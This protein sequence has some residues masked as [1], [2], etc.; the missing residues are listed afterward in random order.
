[1]KVKNTEYIV[2]T[3][4]DFETSFTMLADMHVDTGFDTKKY[5]QI[6]EQIKRNESEYIAIL[7]DLVENINIE[8]LDDVLSFVERITKYASKTFVVLGNHDQQDKSKEACENISLV[9]GLNKI[10]NLILLNNQ[11]FYGLKNAQIAGFN[12]GCAKDETK[13]KFLSQINSGLTA[14]FDEDTFNIIMS[15]SPFN[16]EGNINNITVGKNCDL[17]LAGHTHS[18][19][20]PPIAKP[21]IP[22]NRGITKP[23][24]H[25]EFSKNIRGTFETDGVR[26]IISGGISKFGCN[27]RFKIANNLY[28]MDIEKV[29]IKRR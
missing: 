25:I 8:N 7:G 29:N 5:E 13:E 26:V 24:G 20:I 6:I 16:F 2:Y 21:F 9:E 19:L 28:N 1:M 23:C 11:Y 18:G 3:E 4:K 17:V 27:S 10:K 22:Q 14:T 12:S 15:H